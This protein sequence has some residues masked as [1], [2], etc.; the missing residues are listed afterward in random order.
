[1]NDRGEQHMFVL[2]DH[3]ELNDALGMLSDAYGVPMLPGS[4]GREKGVRP[5]G[6]CD[7]EMLRMFHDCFSSQLMELT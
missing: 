2:Y 7:D 3:R 6:T 5:P 1:M 4:D